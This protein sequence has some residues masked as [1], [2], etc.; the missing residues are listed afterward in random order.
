MEGAFVS[1]NIINKT[2]NELSLEEVLSEKDHIL[3]EKFRTIKHVVLDEFL[4]GRLPKISAYKDKRDPLPKIRVYRDK[5][6]PN[7]L[8]NLSYLIPENMP[9]PL[10]G[11]EIFCVL[12]ASLLHNI[13]ELIADKEGKEKSKIKID[14]YMRSKEFIDKRRQELNLS[15]YEASLIG[16]IC[17]AQGM[18]NLDYLEKL[19]Y[20][21]R[22]YGEIRVDL[23]SALLRLAEALDI[24]SNCT[25]GSLSEDGENFEGSSRKQSVG[26]LIS[27]VQINTVPSWDIRL[28]AFPT[29]EITEQPLYELRNTI[30]KELDTVYPVL[31]ASGIFFKKVELVLNQSFS[32]KSMRRKK[33]PFLLLAPFNARNAALFAGRDKEIQQMIE[34][35]LGRRL[36]VLIGESG[37]GKTSLVE[38]GVI[39]K[40]KMYDYKVIRF[41]FQNHP[42]DS[43]R[44]E[45]DKSSRSRRSRKSLIDVIQ[46]YLDNCKKK[47]KLLIIGDSLEQMFTVQKSQDVRMDFVEH[48]S[49]VLGSSCPVTFLFCIREDYLPDLYNLSLDLADLYDRNNTLRLHRLSKQNA[50][51]VLR[52]AS[53]FGAVEL[54][55][56][57]I[58]RVAEDLGYEGEGMIYP[59]FLQIVGYRLYAAYN[60]H[61]G[62]EHGS[63]VIPEYIYDKLG[64]VEEIVNRYLDG[65]LDQYQR[66]DRPIVGQI[67]QTMVTDYYTK[68]RVKREDLQRA[69]PNCANLDKLLSSLVQHRI[70]RRSLGEYELVHDFLARRVIKFIEKKR[71]LS[72][73]VRRALVY[74]EQNYQKVELTSGDISK[75][76][77]VSQM[78]LSAL[79]R[80][81]L[82]ITIN[83]QLNEIRIAKAK[84]LLKNREKLSV[85]AIKTGFSR[86]STFSRKFRDIEGISALEY[87]KL[88]II[89][90]QQEKVPRK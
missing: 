48:I 58:N 27:N 31:R 86:L 6:C 4:G 24:E 33:N 14:R 11:F 73:P 12:C 8:N 85:V 7:M 61:C 66:T 68:K 55:D 39:P 65:L 75:G 74:I 3:Y 26:E 59:P 19:E 16:E 42:I 41:S 43:L 18:P 5:H 44:D 49:R 28:V 21:I 37:V 53:R 38:A 25:W 71:Y 1:S 84:E 45:L 87:R 17:R 69:V 35:I 52:R 20:S 46:S 29:S 51:N 76:T 70:V 54:S 63:Q 2:H 78:H 9:D 30:Q 23:L 60:R 72:A 56:Q 62:E 32:D 15:P 34:R 13:G 88:Y 77:G 79:F 89:S 50:E 90:T 82:G 22:N 40:L 67:L 64:K 47:T 80:E 83:R 57:L 81:Q 36:V 10:S